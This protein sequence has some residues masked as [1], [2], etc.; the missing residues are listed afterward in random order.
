[1]RRL[2]FNTVCVLFVVCCVGACCSLLAIYVLSIAVVRCSLFV[3]ACYMSMIACRRLSYVVVYSGL[4]DL[5]W[6]FVCRFEYGSLLCL[7]VFML[8]VVVVRG[9]SLF[10]S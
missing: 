10:V 3:V 1:M 4:C 9:C 2:L 5:F 6:R 7:V 8:C